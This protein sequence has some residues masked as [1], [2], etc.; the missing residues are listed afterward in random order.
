[1]MKVSF[2]IVLITMLFASCAGK[3]DDPNE[4]S[5]VFRGMAGAT[6]G[7]V[8]GIS[9]DWDFMQDLVAEK[10]PGTT[11][12]L[13]PIFAPEGEYFTKL[14]LSLRNDSS[15]DIVSEDSFMLQSD[16]AAGLLAPLDMTGWEA[17]WAQ[18]YPGTRDSATINGVVY[19]IPWNTD[20]RGLYY[21]KLLF[22][23]AG[24]PANWQPKDWDDILVACR[25]VKA[26]GTNDGEEIIPFKANLSRVNGE[27]TTM[28]TFLMLLYGTNDKLF[29]NGKWIIESQGLFD[30]LKFIETLRKEDLILSNDVL[31]TTS[32]GPYSTPIGVKGNVGVRLDGS[33][34]A[35]S[36]VNE[37]L[38]NWRD[39][40]SYIMMPSQFGS[41]EKPGVT[42]QGGFGFS[43]SANSKKKEKALEVIRL[44]SS[45]EAL[46]RIYPVSGHL[47]TRMDVAETPEHKAIGVNAKSAEFLPYGHYRPANDEYASVSVEIQAMVDS[48]VSGTSPEQA[49]KL[50]AQS[51]EAMHGASKVTRKSYR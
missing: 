37:G 5:L 39:V 7:R 23:K 13:T 33:W 32:E 36:F 16:V 40:Y 48:V 9:P 18:F 2:L 14:A 1:M 47:S 35:Q 10:M 51:V 17:N 50:F 26:L 11:L 42:F 49:M 12:K 27:A 24:L 46:K 31:L 25:A 15:Y 21:S 41:V 45:Y 38:P 29:E 6:G 4:V 22:Q 19:T 8:E 30:T 20:A 28:Q 43:I 3:A 34:T 44:L